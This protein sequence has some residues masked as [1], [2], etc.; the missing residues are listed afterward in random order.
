MTPFDAM[1]AGSIVTFAPR[2]FEGEKPKRDDTL[3]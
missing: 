3:R 1:R 2:N